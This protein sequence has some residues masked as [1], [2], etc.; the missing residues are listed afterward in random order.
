MRDWVCVRPLSYESKAEAEWLRPIYNRGGALE[1]TVF[2]LVDVATNKQLVPAGRGPYW[3]WPGCDQNP[4]LMADGLAALLKKFTP[5]G[6]PVGIP[7][8]D[9]VRNALN[10]AACDNQPLAIILGDDKIRLS[11]MKILEPIVW[12]EKTRGRMAF[13]ES[14]SAANLK[15][16]SG[17]KVTSGVLFVQPG[18]Y[19]ISGK[20]L[21]SA[22]SPI[23]VAEAFQRALDDFKPIDKSNHRAH[24]MNAVN[25][26]IRWRPMIP[27]EDRGSQQAT[28]GLWGGN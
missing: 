17:S 19:G 26:G 27:V 3:A 1:N 25:K 4:K 10:V 15:S 2:T 5:K 21:S 23:E 20:V 8:I 18:E 28:Q 6:A 7:T 16:V 9:T 22:K 11:I 13:V 14:K 24:L 12:G